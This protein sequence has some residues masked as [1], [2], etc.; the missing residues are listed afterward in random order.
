M[1]LDVVD[2]GRS[3]RSDDRGA[4]SVD[5]AHDEAESDLADEVGDGV[6]VGGGDGGGPDGVPFFVADDV[7]AAGRDGGETVQD[8]CGCRKVRYS[9]VEIWDF[10]TTTHNNKRTFAASCP[11]P[12][13]LYAGHAQA[14]CVIQ[15]LKEVRM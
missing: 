12:Y 11:F 8:V 4:V 3:V 5:F 1:T 13:L 7:G 14:F 2:E 10:L 6:G 9:H 15:F